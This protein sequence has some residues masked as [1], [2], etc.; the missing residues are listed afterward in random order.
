MAILDDES[1]LFSKPPKVKS[2][3][4][5]KFM[6][7]PNTFQDFAVR[8][9]TSGPAVQQVVLILTKTL[10]AIGICIRAL[11]MLFAVSP[12]TDIS[13]PIGIA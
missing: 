11:A 7:L 2:L 1:G 8:K 13:I 3:L 6:V 5:G 4:S 10:C 9:G 12:F